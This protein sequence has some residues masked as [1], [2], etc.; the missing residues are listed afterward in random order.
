MGKRKGFRCKRRVGGDMS[1]V[2]QLFWVVP[3]NINT[4]ARPYLRRH[5]K[6]EKA[7]EASVAWGGKSAPPVEEKRRMK[8]E[9]STVDPSEKKKK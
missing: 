5:G 8:Q 9:A 6:G 1:S 7:L 3:D 4:A 2:P